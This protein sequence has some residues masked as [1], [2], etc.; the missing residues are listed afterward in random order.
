MNVYVGVPL[1]GLAVA[2]AVLGVVAVR[3][4]WVLPS[5]RRHIVRSKLFGYAQLLVATGLAMQVAAVLLV[6]GEQAQAYVRFAGLAVLLV[7]PG[8]IWAAQRPARTAAAR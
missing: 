1:G 3:T 5:Q 4:G 2:V 6:S 8:M 7:A